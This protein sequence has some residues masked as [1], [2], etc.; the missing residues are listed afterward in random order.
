MEGRGF[1]GSGRSA[2]HIDQEQLPGV[3]LEEL[4]GDRVGV[5]VE[6]EGRLHA[7]VH[8]H[9]TLGTQ[10]VRQDLDGVGHK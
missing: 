9:K 5:V 10:F 8:D 1:E 3:A 2:Y 7:H 4:E 6:R